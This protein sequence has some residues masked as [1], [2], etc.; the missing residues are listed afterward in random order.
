MLKPW[1]IPT[2]LAIA[3]IGLAWEFVSAFVRFDHPPMWVSALVILVLLALSISA[4][5]PAAIRRTWSRA[6]I[7]PI[8]LPSEGGFEWHSAHE[9]RVEFVMPDRRRFWW[10][11]PTSKVGQQLSLEFPDGADIRPAL[12]SGLRAA[13][14]SLPGRGKVR[15]RA[16]ERDVAG[17]R[18]RV[19]VRLDI[20]GAGADRDWANAAAHAFAAAFQKKIP[21]ARSLGR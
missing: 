16:W 21:A 20:E 18:S 7:E 6:D 1:V 14:G 13:R 11:E 10:D 4:W 19:R 2:L 8:V 15:V 17:P 3:G 12:R 5:R 9:P